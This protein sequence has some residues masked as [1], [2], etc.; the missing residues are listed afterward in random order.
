MVKQHAVRP[1]SILVAMLALLTLFAFMYIISSMAAVALDGEILFAEYTLVTG[2]TN[3]LFVFSRERKPGAAGV[4]KLRAFPTVLF[5][6][7]VT[8]LSV[9]SPVIVIMLVTAIA[10]FFGVF[11]G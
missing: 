11:I 6:A 2:R 5:V 10:F 3:Q 4:I 8:F 1:A 7:G 9:A